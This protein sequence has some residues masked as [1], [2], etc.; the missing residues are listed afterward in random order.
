MLN[1]K[2]MRRLVRALAWLSIGGM[3][4]QSSCSLTMQNAVYSA[5]AQFLSDYISA[6]L[7]R[8]VPTA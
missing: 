7:Q 6:I 2:R 4:I 8:Y 5:V 1:Q 3:V